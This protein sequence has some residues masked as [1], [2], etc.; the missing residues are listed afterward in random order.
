MPDS[1]LEKEP[2]TTTPA[3][4][5]TGSPD[6]VLYPRLRKSPFFYSSREHGVRAYSVYNHHYHPR[7]YT[8]PVD[9]YWAL[10]NRV[11]LWDVGVERQVEISGS[12]AFAFTQMLVPRNLRHCGVGQCKYVFLTA[13]DGGILNDPVLLR[14]EENRF[15]LSLADSDA[16]LWCWGLAAQCDMDVDIR[17]ID[18]APLQVQGPW[19]KHVMAGLFDED[20]LEL[21]YYWLTDTELDGIPV[22]VSRTGYSGEIGYEIYVRDATEHGPAVWERVF[23]A[24]RQYGMQAVGPCHIRRIEAGMLAFGCDISYDTNPYEADLGYEWMV[25]FRGS[26]HFIGREALLRIRDQGVDRK[27]VGVLI[28]G[29]S[30]GYFTDGSMVDTFP[31]YNKAGTHIG[32]VTSACRS[33]QLD[34]N[35]GYA[36]V[37]VE[38]SEQGTPLRIEANTGMRDAVVVPKPFYDRSK[39]KPKG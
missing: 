18:V 20:V 1:V 27:L 3:G 6:V 36:M 25:D 15:W 11:T 39:S 12:D 32:E 16:M 19:A 17:E 10:V 34:R 14:L 4:P 29:P 35:I 9:E 38:Y 8:D 2:G 24:G 30:V 13:P 33:P 22:V 7:L 21:P 23:E 28:D 31:V 26:D 5:A 37:P